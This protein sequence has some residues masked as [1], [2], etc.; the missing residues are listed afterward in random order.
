MKLVVGLGN[1][2]KEY[3]FTKHNIGFMFLDY[4][5][6]IYNFKITKKECDS[7]TSQIVINNEK[8]I[9]A[10]PQTYMNLSGNAVVKLKN[11]YKIDVKDILVVFDDI[12]IEFGKTKY[13]L[14]GSGGSHNGA[15]N[16]VNMLNS[17]DFRRLKIGIGGLKNQNQDLKDFVLQ[18]FSKSNLQDLNNIFED[19]LKKFEI[20]IQEK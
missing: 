15:K 6:Q 17:K 4:L 7:L 2:D 14:N 5:S 18:K 13:R 9:F 1:P 19:A 12:D 8:V 10:K 11:Y 3:E 16:I 20:F